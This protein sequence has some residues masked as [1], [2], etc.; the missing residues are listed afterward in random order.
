MTPP[1]TESTSLSPSDIASQRFD[2]ARRGYDC[3]EVEAFLRE[4]ADHVDRLCA[5]VEWQRARG[6]DL[7]RRTKVARRDAISPIG[8]DFT[9]VVTAIEQSISRIQAETEVEARRRLAAARNEA[10]RIVEA[11]RREARA[12]VRASG[13][14]RDS[15]GIL[16]IPEAEGS[17]GPSGSE[18]RDR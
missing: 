14:G 12:I 6:K 8:R 4:V 18:D 13:F 1:D 7:R 16:R 10:E 9:E 2:L 15:R 3:E 11:A 17:R 5:E